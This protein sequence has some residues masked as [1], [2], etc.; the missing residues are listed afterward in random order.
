MYKERALLDPPLFYTQK[1]YLLES[2]H[3]NGDGLTVAMAD[4]DIDLLDTSTLGGFG[5][6]TM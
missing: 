6:F 3:S 4:A 1:G 2:R 5:G